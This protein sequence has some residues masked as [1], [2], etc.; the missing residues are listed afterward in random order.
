MAFKKGIF[1]IGLVATSLA[2]TACSL[3]V[4]ISK[5]APENMLESFSPADKE[6]KT[7]AAT[8]LTTANSAESAASAA[9]CAQASCIKIQKAALGKIF[10]LMASGRTA[11]STPQWYDLKPLVV[12]FEKSGNRIAILGEN[13]NSI[14]EEIRTVN[15]IQTFPIIAEDAASIT[16]DWGQGLKTFVLQSSYDVDAARGKNNDLTESSFASLPVIDSFVRNIK[17][18][19]KNIELEQISKIRADVV[20]QSGDRSLN[21][22]NREETL[23]MNVQIRSYNLSQDFKKKEY[24][25]SRRAGFFVTKVSKKGYSTEITNLITKW[26]LSPSKGPIVVRVSAA[27][28]ED[29]VQAVTEG[30]LYWNKVFGRDV[31]TVKTGV[32]PQAG[33]ED[34]SIFIRWIPW[35]DSGAAYA[36]GQSDPLTGEVLRA[37]VF[38]PSVFTRVGS[39]DL[40]GL[41]GDSPVVA[42]G[43]VACDLTTSLKALNDIAREAS[44]SQRL[45]LAQDSVRATVAHELGHALGLR[46]NFAGSFSAKVS[47]KEIYESA[48][49]YL[50]DPQHQGLETSTSIMDYVSGIDDV[51]MAAKIKY[52]PLSYDKMAMTWAYSE[53]DKAL[54]EAVSKYCTDDDIA[55]ATSQGLAVYGCERFDAGNNPLLRKYLDA[56]S[57]KESFVKVLFASIIGRAYP[58]DQPEVTLPMDTVLADTMKWGKLNLEPLKF[59]AQVTMD[60]T[61]NSVAAPGFASLENVKA[62]QVLYSKMGLDEALVK[63]RARSLAEAGGYANIINTLLRDAD[64]TISVA[65]LDKQIEELK[66]AAYFTSGKTLA[67]REYTLSSEDQVKILRFFAKLSSLN[68]KVLIEDVSVLLPKIEEPTQTDSG[69]VIVSSLLGRHLITADEA[70]SLADLYLDLNEAREGEQTVKVGTGLAKEVKVAK[71][72]LTAEERAKWARVLSSKGLRFDV[73]GKLALIRKAQYD[74]VNAFLKEIDPQLDLTLIKKPLEVASDL[75]GKGLVDAGASAWLSSEMN[76]LFALSKVQ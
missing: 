16:F 12:S 66:N 17:F 63:E 76:V 54:D 43:A 9:L 37:Q 65:W 25:K 24:D 56:K 29:Y 49:T 28:P 55:L 26:D 39:A 64:G 10:L 53:D 75:L 8:K 38:M 58:G 44:D 45:R 30:A 51:L 36:I 62:G 61:K 68:R 47:T 60:V 5:Q 33:P 72:Y 2:M 27:V 32:D 1:A 13:Y 41:N 40:V 14:Y 7:N 6:A 69:T 74:K 52:A 70:A 73:D 21:I 48:K 42:A 59:V 71:V 57:E 19:E 15:L 23:A 20:K 35:L 50:K 31:I 18:D 46:H 67:G 11:G 22:E 3:N 34:R 4:D